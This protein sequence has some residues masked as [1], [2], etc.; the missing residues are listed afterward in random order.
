MLA[1]NLRISQNAKSE[2]PTKHKRAVC[3]QSKQFLIS[4]QMVKF[5]LEPDMKA[6]RGSRGISPLFL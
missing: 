4:E 3:K 5:V 2:N 1:F 6:Q